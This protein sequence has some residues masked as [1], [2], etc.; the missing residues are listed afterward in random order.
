MILTNRR[1]RLL[2]LSLAGMEVACAL[3]YFLLLA[4]F[5][6]GR[7][8][9]VSQAVV[10]QSPLYL[11]ALLWLVMIVYMLASDFLNR[12]AVESPLRE[13]A[14]FAL[15]LATTVLG[16]QLLYYP[17]RPYTDWGWLG[18]LLGD[19]LN[20]SAGRRGELML[21][22]ANAF[23]WF[24]VASAT[25]RELSF[26]SVG[27]SFRLGMLL[28]II[29]NALL[30]TIGG[31]PSQDATLIFALFFSFG[32]AAV[33]LARI[34]Q[35]AIGVANSSGAL[36]P[37]GRFA[38]IILAIGMT[39]GATL[40]LAP[41]S[42]PASLRAFFGLFSPVWN[43]LGWLLTRFLVIL[44]LL[45]TPLLEGLVGLLR[46]WIGEPVEPTQAGEMAAPEPLVIARLVEESSLLRYCIVAGLIAVVLF[47]ILMLFVKTMQR[48]RA[49]EEEEAAGE[50]IGFGGAG[51]LRGLDRLREWLRLLRQ[52]GPN[53]RLLAAI[54]VQNMY[55]N[56]SRLARRRGFGRAPA[57]SPDDYLPTLRL[58]F[59]DH[60]TALARLTAGYMRVHYGDKPVESDEL[61]GL[62]QDYEEIASAAENS[63]PQS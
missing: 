18:T 59:P 44:L 30:S 19:I 22:F 55:A 27:V 40:A 13:I 31:R 24:R 38:Q 11:F 25:G 35:K 42:A 61:A 3:P 6:Q 37:W 47:V 52:F 60:E 57:Q 17:Q 7:G 26:F 41:L 62:R 23:L 45:L 29:G 48:A 14:V 21:I 2:Y 43:G 51:A 20:L 49:D 58:A 9:V 36:L 32:L 33:A 39:V 16:M 1:H 8:D 28:A 4:D 63:S 5:W 50:E 46:R 56:V 15:L 10:A 53:R 54:S 12:S 34:D